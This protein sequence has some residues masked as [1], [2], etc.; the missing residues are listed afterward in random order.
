[1]F[2]PAAGKKPGKPGWLKDQGEQF[3]TAILRGYDRSLRWVLQHPAVTMMIL[4]GTILLNVFLF[5]TVKKGFF[6]QQ[7]N[8]TI[9]GSVLAPQDISFQSMR[10]LTRPFVKM[11]KSDPGVGTVMGFTGGYGA[12]NTAG[13]YIALKPLQERKVSS[14]RG[15]QPA[16]S[17]AHGHS[18]APV[19]SCGP[20]RTFAWEAAR[21]MPPINTPSRARMCRTW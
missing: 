21:A 4:T 15:R 16:A 10:S 18:R 3:F 19:C 17:E 13:M 12:T 1:M 9:Q 14:D 7:D 2:A 11:I 5:V 6:P 8:G 20:A